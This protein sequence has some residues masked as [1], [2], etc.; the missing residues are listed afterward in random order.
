[1][2]SFIYRPLAVFSITF[3]ISACFFA[4]TDSTA[5]LAIASAI[6]TAAAFTTMLLSFKTRV[7]KLPALVLFALAFAALF[8]TLAVRIPQ[9]RCEAMAGQREIHGSVEHVVYSD[10]ATTAYIADVRINGSS[11]RVYLVSS[12]LL[13][14]GDTFTAEA[15]IFPLSDKNGYY[16]KDC[17]YLEGNTSEITV[18]GADA[19]DLRDTFHNL[20]R[21][22]SSV[23]AV[24]L[25]RDKG[26]FASS[27]ILGDRSNF[28]FELYSDL[29]AMG[30][31]HL[32]A[33]SGL[34]LSVICSLVYLL[35]SSFR[36]KIR[37]LYAV[38]TA[39]FYILLTDFSSSIVR[40]AIMLFIC[41][42]LTLTHRPYDGA[43]SLGLTAITVTLISPG[44]VFDIGF[45]LSLAAVAGVFSGL[46]LIKGK[47]YVIDTPAKAFFRKL[48]TPLAVGIGASI[49][50]LPV[51]AFH[52]MTM[53]FAG[54]IITIP[55]AAL[56]T[57][58]MW[59]LIPTL[60]LP[61]DFLSDTSA[62]LISLFEDAAGMISDIGDFRLLTDH[63]TACGIVCAFA[64]FFIVIATTC[65]RRRYAPVFL[66]LSLALLLVFCA[67]C[68]PL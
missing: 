44:A 52:R 67:L 32:I 2:N 39:V 43:T 51:L 59:S 49:F 7:G 16:L 22:L 34:H 33:L 65:D 50:V 8:T 28:P 37:I 55:L 30:V 27:V 18:T 10:K 58:T 20:N 29:E 48:A 21:R 41:S 53:T 6:L 5:A 61:F 64:A 54:A 62:F 1:M 11:Y 9:S 36:K 56:L 12:E 46:A 57:V 3:Y 24:K 63:H 60:F 35:T 14:R 42:A 38:A 4:Q 15:E 13:F 47:W 31:T 45:Q 68:L 23:Y 26:G 40:A 66:S 17:V 25:G 19:P